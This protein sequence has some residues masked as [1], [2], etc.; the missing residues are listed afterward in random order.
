MLSWILAGILIS[1]LG[2][3]VDYSNK[4]WSGTF[5]LENTL[6]FYKLVKYKYII[7]N[8]KLGVKTGAN[9]KFEL[10][11]EKATDKFFKNVGLSKEQ[12]TGCDY[13]DQYLYIISDDPRLKA[14]LK[15]KNEARDA[16]Y[17]LFI[18][19]I[20]DI[21]RIQKIECNGS[22]L[23][24]EIEPEIKERSIAVEKIKELAE[25]TIPQLQILHQSLKNMSSDRQ[26]VYDHKIFPA[27]LL[28]GISVG[29]L[30]G[31][32]QNYMF[33]NTVFPALITMGLLKAATFYGIAFT[34]LLLMIWFRALIGT[35]RAHLVFMHIIFAGSI[36][37][38]GSIFFQLKHY[39]VEFDKNDPVISTAHVIEKFSGRCE[40]LYKET[41]YYVKVDSKSPDLAKH[42]F[43]IP[44][45]F[46]KT[47]EKNDDVD[48]TVHGGALQYVWVSSIV[49]TISS[50]TK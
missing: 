19:A 15:Y 37:S 43:K 29:S 6:I 39:N 14:I 35:S 16:V 9:F 31:T 23:L 45:A 32:V 44:Y 3:A 26:R 21:Y 7:K 50:I 30:G 49:K 27:S 17:S 11:H 33:D 8:I 40:I 38:I 1:L 42:E 34:C 47:I 22:Y 41:C 5:T 25:L 46:Y 24:I 48:I 2:Y 20:E 36:G 4:R 10:R 13:F 18:N 12:Q 28:T